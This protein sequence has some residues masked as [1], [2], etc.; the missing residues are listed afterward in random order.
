MLTGTNFHFTIKDKKMDIKK[1]IDEAH[2]SADEAIENAQKRVWY[3]KMASLEAIE[4]AQENATVWYRKP[5]KISNGQAALAV[6]V[7]L[8][9]I[10]AF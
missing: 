7:A 3:R 4:K 9:A 8:I 6:L 2:E 1:M 5:C 10:L